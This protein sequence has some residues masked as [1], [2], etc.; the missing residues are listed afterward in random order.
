M[1]TRIAALLSL[2]FLA[3]SPAFAAPKD[4]PVAYDVDVVVAGG[5]AGAVAAAEA[6]ARSGAKVMLITSRNYL[7]EDVAGTMQLWLEPGE[8]PQG[9]LAE[10]L[11]TDPNMTQMPG[12]NY[13]YTADQP[14][15]KRHPDTKKPS[16]LHRGRK[17]TD[18][19]HESVQ[20][21]D[22]VTITA[23]LGRV[24]E[25]KEIRATSFR[26]RNDFEVENVSVQVSLDGKEWKDLG[27]FTH[28]MVT[29]RQEFTIPLT[30]PIRYAKL[31]F[32]RGNNAERIL[33]G[34]VKF[35]PQEVR[36][37]TAEIRAV[38]PLHAKKSLEK[39][40]TDAGAS[41]LFGCYATELLVDANGRAAGLVMSN[42][43]GVQAIRAKAVIDA[44]E[45]GI[46]AHAAG[47]SFREASNQPR[48]V[49]WVMIAEK[50]TTYDGLSARKLPIPVTTYN[51]TGRS[52]TKTQA[53]WFEYTFQTDVKDDLASRLAFEAETRDWLYNPTQLYTADYPTL[54]PQSG[55][56]SRMK[57]D[58]GQGDPA[59]MSLAVCQ[60]A[61]LDG[62]WVLGGCSD[63][64]RD[65]AESLA[66]PLPMLTL[67][68]RLG[69][70]VAKAVAGC[71]V[72]QGLSVAGA[73]KATLSQGN[74]QEA[75]AGLRPSENTETVSVDDAMLPVLASYDVVVVGGG[76]SGAPA[77]IAAAR[78]GAKTLLVEHLHG[79]GG[80]GTLGM[81]GKYWYGN[82]VGFAAESPQNPIEVRMQ[83]YLSEM[84]KAGGD[85]WFGSTG[86]GAVTEGNRV[87]GVVVAT[88]FGKGI[89]K[90]KAVIDGTGNSDIA[91]SAGAETQFVEAFF[92]LQ[93]SHIPVREVGASYM[94]GN[95]APIDAADPVDVTA[96]MMAFPDQAFDRGQIIAS[97]ERCRIVGD[98]ELDWLDQINL[99]T[100]PDSI[101]YG[102]SDYDSHGYQVHP[103]FML[104]PPRVP[105]QHRKQ[106]YSYVPYRCLLPKGLE[107]ILVVGLGISAHRD[108]MPIVRMQPELMNIGYAAGLA[109]SMSAKSGKGLREIDVKELQAKL[110]AK[111]I[112]AEDVPKQTDSYPVSLGTIIKAVAGVPGGFKD[113]GHL[114]ADPER[115]LPLLRTAYDQAD[116]RAKLAYA[117]VLGIMGDAHG[118]ATLVD[119]ANA[120]LQKKDFA[121]KKQKDGMDRL[122][123]LLWSLGRSGVA[124]ATAA[125]AALADAGCHHVLVPVP[126]RR[127]FSGG[128]RRRVCRACPASAPQGAD[129]E[130]R[131]QCQ[132]TDGRRCPVSL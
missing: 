115:A 54:V 13:S 59:T 14:T 114:L 23:D 96:A 68:R 76:T 67:G 60:P 89:V 49:R 31:F 91:A 18:V 99:R 107:G 125:I 109:A 3:L 17:A 66:H 46:L 84:H 6:A 48:T 43:M 123:Q 132:R 113:L 1:H 73:A 77:G 75:L 20:Y 129:Q 33:L 41:F 106:F 16:R 11:F 111:G 15:D 27:A 65:V 8:T 29:D 103:Y 64:S 127:R 86:C 4:V 97:R 39:A 100:F 36:Q 26:R 58:V 108:A 81:I 112:L 61:E 82:R 101:T 12:L 121:Y 105:G 9:D 45:N 62:L 56:V 7:G 102:N 32:P 130:E 117:E 51:L 63:V 74:V 78:S 87:T 119:E 128:Q 85:V 118:V 104:K 122:D 10:T 35:V 38:R 72:P 83:F 47:V 30:E 90:A 98:Y 70:Q 131:G 44:T 116:G 2:I 50:P 94:N 126:C 42:R 34:E 25:V 40:L 52:T 92:A 124:K 21:P 93:N 120:F 80:V 5:S 79:L 95:R 28:Q 24:G 22:S 69:E 53:S 55:I 37:D 57:G 88:P 71:E 19:Q 110:V